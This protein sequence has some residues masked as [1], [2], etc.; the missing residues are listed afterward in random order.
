MKPP[1]S[2]KL[3]LP[4]PFANQNEH[5]TSR[6]NPR[7]LQVPRWRAVNLLAAFWD[8]DSPKHQT[9]SFRRAGEWAEITGKEW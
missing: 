5:C 4:D 9:S 2:W 6:V 3:A 1:V 8:R 7:K